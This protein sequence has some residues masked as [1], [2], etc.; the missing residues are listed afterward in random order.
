MIINMAAAMRSLVIGCCV[1][2]FCF[3]RARSALPIVVN[4]WPFTN[5]TEAGM[6]A[7]I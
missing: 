4:T 7:F 5:A 6:L 2:V 3:E 1:A